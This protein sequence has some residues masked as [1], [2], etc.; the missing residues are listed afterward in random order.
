MLYSSTLLPMSRTPPAIRRG[1][2]P[3]CI[4][5]FALLAT[6]AGCSASKP[7]RGRGM[8]DSPITTKT[9]HLTCLQQEHLPVQVTSP[10][11]LQIG[12]LPNGPTV[13]FQPTPGT[14]Q[15][16][17]IKGY[18]ATQGAEVIGSAQLY[19]NGADDGELKQIETCLAKGVSG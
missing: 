9:N 4:A 2:A 16:V 8:V 6:L 10:I 18:G 5:G 19:P 3:T 11:S 7:A 1:L 14:A 12:P 13:V 17:Q 15:G